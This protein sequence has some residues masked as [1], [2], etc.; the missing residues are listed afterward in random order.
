[1]YD[2]ANS[3]FLLIIITAIFPIYFAN[4]AAEGLGPGVATFRYSLATTAGL[5]IIA[6]LAPFLGAIADF[7]A[8]KK[9]MLGTFLAFGVVATGLMFFIERGDWILAAGLFIAANIG[10]N[11]SYVFYDSLLPHITRD[12]REMD[13]VSTAGYALGYLGS[14]VLMV[15]VIAWILKPAWFGLPSDPSAT[16]PTRLAFVA[17][18][19][20]WVGFSIPLFRRV[21]EPQTL[22]ETGERHG[23]LLRAAFLRLRY[24][25][26]ELRGFRNAFLMLV[27]FLIY[28]DGIGTIIRMA[29]IY[30]A[31]IGIGRSALIGSILLVQIIGVP[32]A[33]LFGALAGRI[34]PKHAI[35]LG[36]A[37]YMGI[38]IFGYLMTSAT[39]FLILAVLVG[40]VQGGTQA[41]SRSLFASMVPRSK[42][43]EFFGFF[44]VVEK[45]AGIFGP[46]LFALAIAT[47]GSSRSAILSVIVFFVVGG[48]LLLRVDVEAGRAA[49]AGRIQGRGAG[50]SGAR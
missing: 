48:L 24:T 32:F 28:N 6:I 49:A 11:G 34:G 29:A 26:R 23:S 20:W 44:A 4:V 46:A 15:L 33:F 35:F 16:L 30:G 42:S 17:V 36:L 1:M 31:E 14:A 5:L 8:V 18:A 2:W 38:S 21:P 22:V 47:T 3:A 9:R 41:L 50:G 12:S 25:F 19:L 13:R 40:M 10:A 39:H 7:A 37:T 27:A 43:G 45:F